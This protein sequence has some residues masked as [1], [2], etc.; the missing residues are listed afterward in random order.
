MK[1]I[2]LILATVL[3]A[4]CASDPAVRSDKLIISDT[5]K[6]PYEKAWQR[7]VQALTAQGYPI[8]LSNKQGG[9]IS[10]EGAT[11]RLDDHLAD[12]GKFGGISYL[13]DHRTSTYI[14]LFIDLE[15]ISEKATA[16]RVNSSI[17][18]AFSAGIGAESRVLSC[19]S[20]GKLEKSLISQIKR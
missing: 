13:K 1:S 19:H 7:T 12:C 9:V 10:V 11:V 20:S 5:L 16:I 3:L 2:F 4:A 14:T 18:A 8:D 6:I 17:K 15:K